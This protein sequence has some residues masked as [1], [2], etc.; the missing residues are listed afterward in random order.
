MTRL[1]FEAFPRALDANG[2]AISGA[3]LGVYAAGT[4][5]PIMI[6][7]DDAMEVPLANPVAADAAGFFP[8]IHLAPG[9]HKIRVLDASGTLLREHDN[10]TTGVTVLPQFLTVD[11]GE[12]ATALTSA[13]AAA[14]EADANADL[15]GA[16]ATAA[17]AAQQNAIAAA[18]TSGEMEYYDT[19]ADAVT[20]ADPEETIVMIFADESYGGARTLNRVEAGSIVKKVTLS[21]DHILLEDFGVTTA[22]TRGGA[23]TDYTTEV[24]AALTAAAGKRLVF[25]GWVKI[26]DQV[27]APGRAYITVAGGRND[28]GLVIDAADFNMSAD[29]VFVA[30]DATSLEP[31]ALGEFALSCV[32]PSAPA[33]R[34]AL[35]EYPLLVDATSLPRFRFDALRLEAGWDGISGGGTNIGGMKWGL[36][37]CSCFNTNVD[38]QQALDF[39][40][41][42]TIHCWPFG[43]ASNSNLTDLFYDG[44]TVALNTLDVDDLTVANLQYFRSKIVTGNDGA[45]AHPVKILSATGDRSGASLDLSGYTQISLLTCYATDATPVSKDLVARQGRHTVSQILI[46]STSEGAVTVMSGAELNIIGGSI[47]NLNQGRVPVIVESGGALNVTSLT[48]DWPTATARGVSAPFFKQEAGGEMQLRGVRVS[49]AYTVPSQFLVQFEDDQEGNYLDARGIDPHFV[50][51]GLG[52]SSVASAVIPGDWGLGT[53][54][55]E[56]QERRTSR[57]GSGADLKYIDSKDTATGWG[58]GLFKSRGTP[59]NPTVP[60]LSDV[61]GDIRFGAWDGDSYT[62]GAFFR[63][64]ISGS[65]SDGITPMTLA[66]QMRDASG[67]FLNVATF[68]AD[69]ARFPAGLKVPN[70]PAYADDA[71]A[72]ADGLTAGDIYRT[73]SDIK[74]KL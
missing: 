40:H 49:G 29:S 74:V 14:T 44:D 31:C 67:T 52:S 1:Q 72:G 32:Q 25:T 50:R 63:A 53:Y 23:T 34:A 42:G 6:Y 33:N 8:E 27:V 73:G 41:I 24:Q 36:I 26:T 54:I 18:E 20:G 62:V 59:D 70:L 10:V 71:A 65:I 55:T 22:A 43:F 61:V 46:R 47:T 16:R 58:L 37:E 9:V 60:S 56:G 57:A 2:D 51:W 12:V 11:A 45:N 7:S 68:S 48:C 19:R 15:A 17:L 28:G 69:G 21:V 66:I 4:T 30:G 64:S 39:N 13:Q 38:V 3:Q 35:N 5:T